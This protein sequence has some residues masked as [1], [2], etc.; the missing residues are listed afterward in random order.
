VVPDTD[1]PVATPS[2][3]ETPLP[4]QTST[5]IGLT[6]LPFHT[7]VSPC[8]SPNTWVVYI[9]QPGDSLYHVSQ[10]YGVTVAELQRAN[11]LGSSTTLHTGQLLYVPPWAPI[12]PTPTTIIVVLPTTLP[13]DIPTAKPTHKPT[14]TTAP[15]LA[16]GAV[17]STPKDDAEMV[18]VPAGEFSMGSTVG[19]VDEQPV[20]TVYLDAYWIDK[21]EV[22]NE[23]Y[24]QC[25]RAGTC[26]QP[27]NQS[28]THF[29]YYPDPVYA[30]YPVINLKWSSA[31]KYCTWAGGRLPTEAEWEKAAVG[32]DGRTYP[33]GN[34]LPNSK[35]LNFNN[36][37][38]DMMLAESFLAGA[39][40]YGALN[41]AGNAREWVADW[42]SADYYPA[43]PKSNPTGPANGLYKVL[44][45]GSWHSGIY[46]VR[47][48]D[49]SWSEPDI[50]DK[51][52]GFR[53]VVSAEQ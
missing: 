53:C 23:M 12:A 5:T 9:V 34:A 18:Y 50:R 43:S 14:A 11:C 31:D 36:P 2:E 41:M 46:D 22:T 32:T 51:T 3:S 6:P 27:Q 21:T 20:H 4:S 37:V 48:A 38:G 15:T 52:V 17:R 29:N 25:V 19:T 1:T 26:L 44:R 28:N 30:D 40:P 10:I 33:W 35:L 16:A 13:T 42:Y 47:S 49:R 39:S 7:Q 8:G 24:R 45:G